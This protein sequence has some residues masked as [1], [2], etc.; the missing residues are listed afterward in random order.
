MK[1]DKLLMVA[2]LAGLMSGAPAIQA[3]EDNRDTCKGV[4]PSGSNSCGANNH[5]CGGYARKDWDKEEWVY[6]NKGGCKLVQDA[7]KNPVIKAYV[8]E[9]AKNAYKY[10][11]RAPITKR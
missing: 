6:V 9:V 10:W 4:S 11:R 2:A 7:M 5:A 3:A 8:K 1:K